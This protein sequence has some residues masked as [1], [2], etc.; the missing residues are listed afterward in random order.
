[1]KKARFLIFVLAAAIMLLGASYAYWQ[2]TLTIS[3][4][5]T[6]GEL[7][8]TFTSADIVDVDDYMDVVD[9]SYCEVSSSNDN[10][11]DI[12][13]YDMY[14]GAE[15]TV[16][17]TLENSGTMKAKVKDFVVS[18]FAEKAFFQCTSLT[19]DGDELISS[20]VSLAT[21]ITDQ[22]IEIEPQDSVVFELTVQIDPAAT[23]TDV[24]ELDSIEFFITAD[25]LQY[26]DNV[27]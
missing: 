15:A 27:N 2:E 20:P 3:N 12:G 22:I 1:M 10:N 24:A 16:T 5:V 18:N 17:F 6:T 13:L 23:E 14:P 4:T 25:G 9:E 8:F 19:V 21:N 11:I 7:D 26:N